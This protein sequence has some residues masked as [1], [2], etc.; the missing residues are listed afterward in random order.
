AL[1]VADQD[2]LERTAEAHSVTLFPTHQL[3]A[4]G[5]PPSVLA[6][7]AK[8]HVPTDLAA[9]ADAAKKTPRFQALSWTF[10]YLEGLG[11]AAGLVALLGMVLY[12]QAR[13][14]DREVSYALARR[15]GLTSSAHGLSVAGELAGMLV[16]AFVIG[17]ALAV[18]AAALVYGR[19]DPLPTLPPG[20]LLRVPYLSFVAAAG[21]L[22]AASAA[23]AWAVQRRAD[24]VNVAEVMRLAG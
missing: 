4:K 21:V 23:G 20:P 9:T 16:A 7:L 19:L 18:V 12:L 8:A 17:T 11:L 22:L 15:M 2:G 5:D 10:G 1:V 13:Q 14:R 6:A 24:R 3:W